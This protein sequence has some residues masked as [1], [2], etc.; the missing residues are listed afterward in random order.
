[1]TSPPIPA[2]RASLRRRTPLAAACAQPHPCPEPVRKRVLAKV[3]L[4][5]GL[6]QAE[7]DG[8]DRHMTSLA[9]AAGA[10]LFRAGA[11]ATHMYVL[12]SGRAKATRASAA[13][14]EVV[15]DMLAPGDLFGGLNT[16]GQ[17]EHGETVT[18]LTTTCA[19]RIDARNFRHVLTEYPQ[20]A[21][22]VLDDIAGRLSRAHS[23]ITEQSTATATQRV[24][25]TLL[26][27]ANKFGQP[28]QGGTLIQIPL[29]RADLAGMSGTTTE[30]VSRV[31]SALRT[32]GIIESGRRWTAILDA[33]MLATIATAPDTGGSPIAR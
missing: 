14:H 13:G 10:T 8:I 31:M 16:L 2:P 17:P 19:L 18:A 5:A 1:M 23:T 4:F 27:L 33:E 6:S 15:V 9:W 29:T 7:L 20:I 12:A 21:L 32:D 3:P 25:A 28:H 30:T 22:R 26:R 11:A 24:A